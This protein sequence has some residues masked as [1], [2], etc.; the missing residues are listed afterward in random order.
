MI[1]MYGAIRSRARSFHTRILTKKIED[2]ILNRGIE[3]R[4]ITTYRKKFWRGEG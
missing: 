1:K 3:S 2:P 4:V